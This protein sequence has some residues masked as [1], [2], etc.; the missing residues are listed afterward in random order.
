MFKKSVLIILMLILF[1]L[2]TGAVCASENITD[3]VLD[4]DSEEPLLIDGANAKDTALQV[5]ETHIEVDN[6]VSY[7]KDKAIFASYLKD[8]DNHP[9]QNRTVKIQIEDST[10]NITSDESGKSVLS[11]DI[12]PN[13]Y[14]VNVTFDGDGEHNSASAS[15]TITVKK[16][17][18]AI[19]MNN[20]DTYFG[21]DLFFKVKVYNTITK[22]VVSGIKVKFKVYDSNKRKYSYFWS[23]TDKNGYAKLNKNLKPGLYKI[24]AQIDDSKNKN[25]ISYKKSNK[26]VTVNVKPTKEKGCCSFF[27][28]ISGSESLGGFR[29]DGTEA[30]NLII[31]SYKWA[32]KT[33]IKQYKTDYGYFG[34]MIV[35]SDGWMVGNGGLD[36]GKICKAIE[37]IA[38]KM[39]KSNKI[40]SK[41]LKQILKYKKRLNFGHFSIKAPNGKFA[42]VWKNGFITGKLKPGE[43]L[44]SP[45]V[46]SYYRHGAYTQYGSDPVAAAIKIGAS[47]GYGVNRR[48]ITVFH[49]KT[50]T[51]KNY[52][53][54]SVVNAYSANDNGKLVGRSTAYLKDN[55][56]FK[57]KFFS[58]N[59]LPYSPKYIYLGI[60]KFGNIDKLIKKPTIISAPNITNEFNQTRYFEVAVKDKSTKGAVSGIKIKIKLSASNFTKYFTI[61]TDSKG[62]AKLNTKDLLNGTYSV[63]IGPA[64][65]KYW[66]SAKSTIV[67][68]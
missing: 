40:Q 11:L 6:T 10:Y 45:N 19:E 24:S 8:S 39:V 54:T 1:S 43:F 57:N 50:A 51:D 4:F 14:R 33:A 32:G 23:T 27:V 25:Y 20:Y 63:A 21:S 46:R 31:K 15:S 49:W 64:N 62:V 17:P 29:R 41:Y 56:Y 48:D 66:I 38:S 47:D 36:D 34:H 22:N 37:N 35:T 12:K 7:Y 9:I 59:K 2:G 68:K 60:H 65:N 61:K 42:I 44:S 3:A 53:T 67:I 52:K 16:A 26:K 58:K 28:Q 18:L 30:V 13:V 55:V 5:N